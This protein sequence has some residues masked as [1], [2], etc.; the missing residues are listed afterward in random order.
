MF[1]AKGVTDIASVGAWDGMQLIYLA[2]KEN[3]AKAP[4]IKYIDSMRGKELKSPRGP[5]MIDPEERDIIG[6][7]YIRRIEKVNGKLT[8]ID[9]KT[10]PM[11][12]DP[13]K[14]DH[15]VKK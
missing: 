7:M 8:N 12:K 11:V 10:Y 3:G 13:W 5:I 2:L 6:N 4:G 15:P 9:I 1:G 14:L